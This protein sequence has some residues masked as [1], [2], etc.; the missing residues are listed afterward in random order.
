MK[1]I[2]Y[3]QNFKRYLRFIFSLFFIN[4]QSNIQLI[5][6]NIKVQEN[7]KSTENA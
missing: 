1:N 2:T 6:E 7:V 4:F 5:A 3:K